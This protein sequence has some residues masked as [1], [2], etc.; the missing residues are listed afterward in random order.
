VQG[1]RYGPTYI[2]QLTDEYKRD[3]ETSV[4]FFFSLLCAPVFSFVPKLS[5][6]PCY[7]CRSARAAVNRRI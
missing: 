6:Q 2:L 5:F 7:R 4:F 1:Y 3:L